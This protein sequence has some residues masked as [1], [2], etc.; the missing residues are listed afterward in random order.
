[1][2]DFEKINDQ[3]SKVTGGTGALNFENSGDLMDSKKCTQFCTTLCDGGIGSHSGSTKGTVIK[4]NA[5]MQQL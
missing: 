3:L 5:T 2:K 4:D 1:M